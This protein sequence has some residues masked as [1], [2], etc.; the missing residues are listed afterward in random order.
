MPHRQTDRHGRIPYLCLG[1]SPGCDS[2]HNLVVAQSF[3]WLW[4]RDVV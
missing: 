1:L 3:R 2:N 4:H